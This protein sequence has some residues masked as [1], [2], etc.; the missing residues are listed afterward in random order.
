MVETRGGALPVPQRFGLV[1]AG[2]ARPAG[3]KGQPP[4][5][6]RTARPKQHHRQHPHEVAA[7][8]PTERA[9][10]D[11]WLFSTGR[12]VA[13]EPHGVE[14]LGQNRA[15]V[16]LASR[17]QFDQLA[18]EFEKLCAAQ[19]GPPSRDLVIGRGTKPRCFSP[20]RVSRC[21]LSVDSPRET[22]AWHSTNKGDRDSWRAHRRRDS[23]GDHR[24]SK[25]R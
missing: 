1:R 14:A 4:L 8:Q 5:E 15:A 21:P 3:A 25:T 12:V 10:R 9:Q 16:G 6:L 2:R 13:R 17:Q 7:F 11:R 24:K 20:V 18:D 19:A 22:E 23:T